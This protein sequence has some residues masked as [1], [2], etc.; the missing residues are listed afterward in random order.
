MGSARFPQVVGANVR[1]IRTEIAQTTQAALAREL[2]N[3]GL[4]WPPSRVAQLEAGEVS[5]TV[6][7]LLLVAAALDNVT[8]PKER[9]TFVDLFVS[10][11]RLE[12]APGI[13][14][15]S[16]AAIG[17]IRGGPANGLTEFR[18]QIANPGESTPMLEAKAAYAR[19]DERVAA[20]L[21]IDRV[22]MITLAVSLWGHNL[23]AERDRRAQEAG[24]TSRVGKARITATLRTEIEA[25]MAEWG[26]H[27]S[28]ADAAEDAIAGPDPDSS[29][30]N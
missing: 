17:V 12:L 27:D 16:S 26:E 30:D 13:Y 11:E 1:R 20:E 21:G 4:P 8:P 14:V 24:I 29:A 7:T 15:P 28:A 19:P 9:I 10:D 2:V 6:P 25:R 22:Y 18:R 23:S 3:L 5:P